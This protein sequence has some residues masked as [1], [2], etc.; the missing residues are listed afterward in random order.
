M[1]FEAVTFPITL[2]LLLVALSLVAQN[3]PRRAWRDSAQR[4]PLNKLHAGV[5]GFILAASG[6]ATPGTGFAWAES[7]LAIVAGGLALLA[8]ARLLGDLRSVEG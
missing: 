4:S 1:A 3:V 2:V 8:G 7:V 5:V 6:L